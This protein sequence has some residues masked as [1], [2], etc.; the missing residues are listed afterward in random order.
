M[1]LSRFY[2]ALKVL[3][4]ALLG[5]GL[6]QAQD[7]TPAERA[8]LEQKIFDVLEQSHWVAEGAEDPDRVVYTFTDLKCPYCER[9]WR[10]MRPLLADPD[11][12]TQVRHVVVAVLRPGSYGEG[13]AVL[14]ADDPAAALAQG[15]KGEL[16]PLDPVPEAVG[17]QLRE[18]NALM[19][20]FGIRGTPAT[21]FRDRNGKLQFA[22]GVLQP[23]TLRGQVFQL[24]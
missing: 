10:D 14:A 24:H 19:R 16:K 5:T 4:I 22:P 20:E 13:A 7:E 23:E 18:N 11:N 15:E 9:Q 17:R 1:P 8:A 2:Y 6:A 21:I 12:R 3:L